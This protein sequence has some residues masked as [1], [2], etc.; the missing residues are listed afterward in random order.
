MGVQTHEASMITTHAG[1]IGAEADAVGEIAGDL[2]H[3]GIGPNEMYGIL[4]GS[5]VHPFLQ[6][7][8][9]SKAAAITSLSEVLTSTEATL[10]SAADVY[11]DGEL[12]AT[13]RSQAIETQ[14]DQIDVP[15]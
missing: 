12:D 9:N 15:R 8:V 11:R 7:A 6:A 4:V 5:L 10:S 13:Q 2:A 3:N 1:H 14:I